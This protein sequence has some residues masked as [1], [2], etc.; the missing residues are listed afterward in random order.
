MVTRILTSKTKETAL[1]VTSVSK[2][3]TVEGSPHFHIRKQ[4][5]AARFGEVIHEDGHITVTSIT[6]LLFNKVLNM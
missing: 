3:Q 5:K 6:D 1:T 2:G 4:Y